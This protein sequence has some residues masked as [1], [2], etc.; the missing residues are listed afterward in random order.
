MPPEPILV[1]G[2]AGFVGGHLCAALAA[3]PSPL[4]D[5]VGLDLVA[6]ATA[7]PG[8]FVRADIRRP[9]EL[10]A[11]G[12]PRPAVVVHLAALAEVVTPVDALPDL[13][14]TNVTGTLNVLSA[15]RP[16]LVLF[17]SS[18][19]VYGDSRPTGARATWED[20][21]PLGMYGM[22]K[23]AAE[24]AGRE[25]SRAT[26]GA[27]VSF[28]LGN[29]VGP[30]CRGLVPHLVRSAGPKG[31][32]RLA[33]LRGGGRLVRDYVPVAHVVDV[34]R[35]ALTKRWEPGSSAVFNVGCGRGLTNGAVTTLV[36]RTLAAER[37]G[38]DARFDL[39]VFPGEARR[40]VLDVSAT[41]RRFGLRPPDRKA[42][43]EALRAAVLGYLGGR[44]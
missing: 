41:T 18:S 23:A 4:A 34:L 30:G 24:L 19:A 21:R 36:Q 37:R 42:V 6:P 25:W 1:T 17:A 28:R 10:R 14:A 26:G 35:A 38:L 31:R 39:P 13:V 16:R 22:S 3:S 2:S 44:T 12:L 5:A 11:A 7:C 43:V 15:F 29:V 8:R 9:E 20:V 40:V 33:R 32:P 27:F